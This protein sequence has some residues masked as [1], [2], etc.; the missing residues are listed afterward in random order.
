MRIYVCMCETSAIQKA[1]HTKEKLYQTYLNT[2]YI[3]YT[4]NILGVNL[5]LILRRC[6][7]FYTVGQCDELFKLLNWF[8]YYEF[9]HR[10]KDKE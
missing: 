4:K 9:S 6:A 5:C 10:D 3:K 2:N 1:M 8:P 7:N